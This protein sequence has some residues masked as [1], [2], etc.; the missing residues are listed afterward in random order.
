[1]PTKQRYNILPTAEQYWNIRRNIE[2]ENRTK[3]YVPVATKSLPFVYD[4]PSAHKKYLDCLGEIIRVQE[5][6]KIELDIPNETVSEQIVSCIHASVGRPSDAS[7][8]A[9]NDNEKMIA[10][11]VAIDQNESGTKTNSDATSS[12]YDMSDNNI[13]QTC[14]L[15]SNTSEAEKDERQSSSEL[16]HS[17][18]LI[19]SAS[20]DD[21]QNDDNNINEKESS[22]DSRDKFPYTCN[23]ESRLCASSS[24]KKRNRQKSLLKRPRVRRRT[25]S[26]VAT[27]T[28]GD[29]LLQTGK[30]EAVLLQQRR[31]TLR[32]ASAR[33]RQ[34][35]LMTM[36]NK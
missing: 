14:D 35:N 27:S 5:N 19:S 24:K 25:V 23:T 31:T 33:K 28:E 30:N 8:S 36:F 17:D 3:D 4:E 29:T 12:R 11:T 26:A 16:S 13:D 21:R 7:F 6:R 1:M 18:D 20:D 32:F 9:S 10:N 34:T 15:Y 22:D 2:H